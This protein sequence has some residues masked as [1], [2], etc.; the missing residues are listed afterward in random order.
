MARKQ[1]V[2]IPEVKLGVVGVSRDCFPASLTKKRLKA[3]EAAFKKSKLDAYFAN[4][5]IESEKDALAA[6]AEVNKAG[7]N[8][9]V[10]FLGNFGPEG[11]TTIFQ[12]KFAG[13][14]MVVAAAEENRDVLAADRG[15][16]LCGLL[17]NSYNQH[18][19]GIKSF[20]PQYPVAGPEGITEQAKDFVKIARA[21]IGLKKLKIFTFG[22]RPYDF[23]ACNA[24]IKPFYDLGIEVMEN[25]ELD[26]LQLYQAAASNKK[27]IAEIAD[28][29]A[30]EL[31]NAKANPYPD[32]LPKLA[33]FELALLKF[34]E[35]NLGSREYAVFADKCWPAFESA[36][37][38]VPCYVNSRLTGRGIPVSCEVDLYGAV[39]EYI[40]TAATLEPAT[41]LDINNS[42]PDDILPGKTNLK[43]ARK[44]DLFMGFHCG[45]TCSECLKDFGMRYQLI[46]KRG[47]EP[48]GPPNITR[49]TLE[50]QLRPGPITFFRL[51][52]NPAGK[53]SSYIAEGSILDVK[54]CTFGGTGVFAIPNF[55]RFYRHI[56]VAKGYPHHG[57]VAFAQAGKVIYEIIKLLGVDDIGVP[58]PPSLPYPGE[59]FFAWQEG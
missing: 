39:S 18:L 19:R 53:L 33:Q 40:A 57:A 14:C 7:V 49:G 47:L 22:P 52:A 23:L 17:N 26:L 50:G 5:V 43:G 58:L 10:V 29:M 2:N 1:L 24:P 37:G 16:A 48:D 41:L 6:L 55:A 35:A 3:L 30:K 28:D 9:V 42:V 44:E 8:A 54:P 34:K 38:F 12:E 11:P 32:L 4:V 13:P 21:L 31:G 15:D 46:M 59:N 36:F 51:Q 20:I 25:S 45:N 56:L 27:Q